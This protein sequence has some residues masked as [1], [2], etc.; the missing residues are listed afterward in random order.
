M[1]SAAAAGRRPSS[2]YAAE[3]AGADSDC[4]DRIAAA[5]SKQQGTVVVHL[6][7]NGHVNSSVGPEPG[8][9]GQL[10]Q[11]DHEGLWVVS[12]VQGTVA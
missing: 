7:H 12:E 3:M 10:P 5:S 1:D 11:K 8:N 9:D 4:G 2:L 6:Q